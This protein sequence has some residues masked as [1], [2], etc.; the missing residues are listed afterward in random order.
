M[1]NQTIY[2]FEASISHEQCNKTGQHLLPKSYECLRFYLSNF[3]HFS[4]DMNF[5]I[6]IS[7]KAMKLFELVLNV[8]VA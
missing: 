6:V 2:S 7:P 3:R 8:S 5:F 4:H 1:G